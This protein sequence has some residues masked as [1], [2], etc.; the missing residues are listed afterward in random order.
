MNQ[1]TSLNRISELFSRFSTE[2]DI[3]NSS[4]EYSINNHAEYVLLP[5][6]KVVFDCPNLKRLGDT[7]PGLDLGDEVKGIAFQVTS[8]NTLQKVQ[9]TLK[10]FF[11]KKLYKKYKKIYVYILVESKENINQT[12]VNKEIEFL[13]KHSKA[14]E[15][16]ENIDKINF[17]I[18]V[19]IINNKSV[20]SK[21][22]EINDYNLIEKVLKILE[23]QFSDL[24][25]SDFV[26]EDEF[27]NK[28]KK[29]VETH[30]GRINF[31]GLDLPVKP[32][33]IQLH[34]L[35]VAPHFKAN[36]SIVEKSIFNSVNNFVEN[37][38]IKNQQ[39]HVL[40]IGATDTSTMM[41]YYISN[42]LRLFS[43]SHFFEKTQEELEI[44]TQ[45][46]FDKIIDYKDILSKKNLVILG[47][48]GAGKSLLIK[49]TISKILLKDFQVFSDSE[50][51]NYLPL[52]IELFKFNKDRN[53]I[54]IVEYIIKIL[55]IEYQI[56]G[57]NNE[58]IYK[59]I[60]Q[61]KVLLFWDGLDE[62]FDIQERTEVRN[63]I[64]GFAKSNK[65]SVNIVTSRFES[66]SEVSLDNSQFEVVELQPFDNSQRSAYINKWYNIEEPDENH[67]DTEIK[68]CLEEIKKIDIEL[69]SNPLLLSLILIMYRN[70]LELPTSRLDIYE[71]CTR[72]LV[73]TRDTKEKK[74]NFSLKI[75]NKIATFSKL[76]YWQFQIRDKKKIEYN[77]TLIEIK[78]YL[79][80]KGEFDDEHVAHNA[81]SQFL[82]FAKTRSIYFENNFTHKTFLEYFTAY[83]IFSNVFLKKPDSIIDFFKNHL[84]DSSWKEVLE[85]LICKIDKDQHDFETIDKIVDLKSAIVTPDVMCFY[86]NA[87][88]Y[89]RNI[90]PKKII[91]IFYHS[92][93]VILEDHKPESKNVLSNLIVNSSIIDRLKP[94]FELSIENFLENNMKNKD[95]YFVLF[96]MKLM[97]SEKIVPQ[98]TWLS[99]FPY[100]FI[101]LNYTRFKNKDLFN[102]D[103]SLFVKHFGKNSTL[104]PYSTITGIKIFDDNTTFNW[105]YYALFFDHNLKYFLNGYAKLK[106]LGFTQS[107]LLNALKKPSKY[108]Q[109]PIEMLEKYYLK[110]NDKSIKKFL[111][112]VAFLYYNTGLN[113]Y[114]SESSKIPYGKPVNFKNSK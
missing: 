58:F 80:E 55:E 112:N 87:I 84:N 5:L 39:F 37:I 18:E 94:F 74:L 92:F 49:Y 105:V 95:F 97:I 20:Y 3:Q 47:D 61:E 67:R 109:I 70:A 57:I 21:I 17:S 71:S 66:Y 53:N 77:D 111:S 83:Y 106:L 73:D 42:R 99:E 44:L 56:S 65:N 24:K 32:R 30:F 108:Y 34:L 38:E 68:N 41:G 1:Q 114:K 8:T 23:S 63:I 28:Y 6:L 93:K 26:N 89:I 40:D 98:A 59:V 96:E 110:L 85:L 54:N 107:D 14:S 86:L 88:K 78:K 79:I 50:I 27:Y 101:L 12:K 64:E 11:D 72:T 4:G 9:Y 51:Y 91:E 103:L 82:D 10:Q 48:P 15:R 100:F 25:K 104:V 29:S 62:I 35:F 7:F 81:A 2:V 31:F 43:F 46:E 102:E 75:G 22:K 60:N 76:A 33:E 45:G 52:R 13:K 36:R 16:E 113:R 90:S 69:K 19:N